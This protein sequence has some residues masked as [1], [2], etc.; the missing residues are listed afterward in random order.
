VARCFGRHCGD[1]LFQ[2]RVECS[3][4]FLPVEDLEELA[5]GPTGCCEMARGEFYL[6]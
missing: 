6:L 5:G 3:A 2:K 4:W 1:F